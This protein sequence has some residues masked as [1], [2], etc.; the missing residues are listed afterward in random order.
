MEV[1]FKKL[2]K[3]AVIPAYAKKGDAGLDLIAISSKHD[4]DTY[5]EYGTGLAIA[6]PEGY[7]GLLFPR[8]SVS[9]TDLVLANCVGIVDSGYRGEIKVR[10]KYTAEHP[11]LYEVGDKVVQLVIMPYPEIT[12]VEVADL[13]ATER[14]EGG[15]GHTGN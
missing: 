13:D 1:K 5:A 6:I 4:P 9:K 14:G 11:F 10:F 2:D 3:H 15:F 7:M 12:P 8:S